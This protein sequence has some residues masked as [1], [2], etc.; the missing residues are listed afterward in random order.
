MKKILS[1]FLL[2]FA[3]VQM[4]FAQRDTEH[5]FAPMAAR[6]TVLSNPKQALYFSTDSVTPFPVEIYSNGALLA[7]VTISKGSPQTYDVPLNR[8]VASTNGELFTPGNK[9]LYTKGTKP[10]FVTYRFSVSSHGEILTSKGKAG[11]GTKFYAATAPLE[12]LGSLYNFTTGIL[13]TED[14]TKVTVSNYSANI[15]FTNGW[16]GATNPT[17][18]FTLNKGQS[19]IIEGTGDKALNKEAFIGAKIESDKPISVT[20]GNFN[21]QFAIPSTGYWD[22]SDIIMDQSVPVDRL[23]NEFVVVKGNGNISKR[24]EDALI[25]ATEGGTQ[26]Y[27]NNGT[28]PVATLAEGESYRVNKVSNTNYINQ[29]NNHYNMYIRTTK[30]VYVYQLMA[31][32][33]DS[34]ATLGFNYIPPLNCYLPRKID[35]IGKIKDLPYYTTLTSHIVKLN[36]LTENGAAV[37]VNGAALPATQGPFP[38]SGTTNWVSYSVPDITG[39]VTI[40]S[41]KAVTAG[42]SGGSGVVGYGGYFAGFSSIP[43]IA[44]QT[45]DCIPG[46]VLEVGDSFD[47]YQ[48]FRNGTPIPGATTNSYTPTQSGRYTVKIT[49]GTCPAVITPEYKVF[50]CLKKTT[51]TDTVCDVVK[52]IV[53]TFTNSTQTVVPGTVTILTPPTHGNAIIDPVTG[54]ISYAPS[55]GYI[56][57]DTIVYQFCG[58]DPEF[59]DCE[60]ITLNLTISESPVVKNAS[61]RTCFI[62][63]N[64]ATGLFNLTNALVHDPGTY[65]KKYYPSL[66]DAHAGTNEILNPT[67]Y[68]APTGVVYVK[69]SNANG[70]YRVAEV[71]LTV[72]PPV[73]SDLLTDKIICMENKTTLDAGPGFKSYEW[74]T[75]ATTQSIQNVGV[76]TYWV[77]LKTGDCVTLQTVKVY[78]SE[79]PVISNIDISNNSITVYVIGGTPPY[80]Y[81]IDNLNW[82][83]SNVFTN[84]PR[85]NASVYVK[86]DYNCTPLQVDITIPNLINV[87]TPNND[88]VNDAID[89]SALANKNNLVINIFDRYGTKV[90][91]ADKSNGYKWNGT[92]DGNKKIST[93]NYWYEIGWTE[94]TGK[95][96]AIKFSGWI[97]VK[98]RE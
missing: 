42:I 52:Q 97:L 73:K 22:G 76:G 60:E 28:T 46:L 19:Y 34:N 44:K 77:K 4:L 32:I 78:A 62:E 70:C 84:M 64:P 13:A 14:N 80:K 6:S 53:P 40:T 51:L 93:G 57:P 20:N 43:V 48:W 67:A 47:T 87:I 65:T 33:A 12:E 58:N 36:I 71:T 50:T 37:T 61:L 92:L 26:V 18:T 24:M 5:W 8:M 21:G 39:N 38:V 49:V 29:G 56:G 10:Y 98:N 94:P 45:G 25:I 9:G 88:G 55:F 69:V 85:G 63:S 23:G 3:A 2:F 75:G 66:A 91:Q 83:D 17:I 30:N 15:I 41:T 96:T 72:L 68:V 7:T 90:Y 82:Q 27:I 79:Q 81:S 31:G 89:Y 59:T 86:D 54:V 95:Q 74:S 16:T 35:E 1:I 11:I